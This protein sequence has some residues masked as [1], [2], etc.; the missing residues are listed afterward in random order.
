MLL[1]YTLVMNLENDV[2]RSVF[3]SIGYHF[4]IDDYLAF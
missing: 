2:K 3:L 4:G 1:Y